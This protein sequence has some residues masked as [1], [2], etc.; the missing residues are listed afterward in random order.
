MISKI[1]ATKNIKDEEK[2]YLGWLEG[3]PCFRT[4]AFA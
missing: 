1:F 3:H 2:E 4:I